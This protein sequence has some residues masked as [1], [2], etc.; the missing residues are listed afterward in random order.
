MS[1]LTF[2]LFFLALL[3]STAAMLHTAFA[4]MRAYP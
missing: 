3:I 4:L 1:N 2:R